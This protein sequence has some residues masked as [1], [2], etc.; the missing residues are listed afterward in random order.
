[1]LFLVLRVADAEGNDD[2]GDEDDDDEE[3]DDDDDDDDEN[4]VFFLCLLPGGGG[5]G[6]GGVVGLVSLWVRRSGT[7]GAWSIGIA[8]HANGGGSG[9]EGVHVP[10]AVA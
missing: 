3:D 4:A 1:V 9:S 2:N 5:G 7:T 8:V 6:G 10:G